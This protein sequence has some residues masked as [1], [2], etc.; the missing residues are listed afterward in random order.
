MA[1]S[2]I[3]AGVLPEPVQVHDYSRR[4]PRPLRG[5]E[6]PPKGAAGLILRKGRTLFVAG[7][8]PHSIY[9]VVEG[10]LK[11]MWRDAGGGERVLHLVKAGEWVGI[12]HFF[13]GT[14][15]SI[16]ASAVT[17]CVLE[18]MD[19]ASV[20]QH[21]G[22][23]SGGGYW[24]ADLIAILSANSLRWMETR[25][26]ENGTS[27]AGRL[28]GYLL[29]LH[30]RDPQAIATG[31]LRFP[32]KKAEIASMLDMTAESFSRALRKLAELGLIRLVGRE[33]GLLDPEG[34]RRLQTG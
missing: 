22:G 19:T 5:A 4:R 12:E 24:A 28:A 9:R 23:A 14:P 13:L 27:V 6:S 32:A 34:L 30:N 7:E 17:D 31:W 8:R 3:F 15:Y 21:L 20:W 11:V 33:I 25:Q 29:E 10:T 16:S 18:C 2:E 26:R 1:G